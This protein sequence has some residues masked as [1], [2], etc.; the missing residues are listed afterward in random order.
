MRRLLHFHCGL[1]CEGKPAIEYAISC[2]RRPE[3][4]WAVKA[5][6][7]AGRSVQQIAEEMATLPGNIECFEQ[8]YFDA[9]PYLEPR[10]WLK[11][12][13]CGEGGH[14]WLEVALKRGWPG[15]EEVV[16]RR[17]PHGPRNLSPAVSIAVGRVQDYFFGQE[18]SNIAPSEKDL[19]LLGRMLRTHDKLPFLQ[20]S[21]PEKEPL[22]ESAA[23]NSFKKLPFASREK[24]CYF[25][26]QETE[27]PAWKAALKADQADSA[28][29]A[30]GQETAAPTE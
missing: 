9:R 12:I 5:M 1:A 29:S 6:V 17:L 11:N 13:C 30:T 27:G 3:S 20:D 21:L 2:L 14:R 16:L 19:E 22:P 26:R 18:A 10:F 25:L 28:T 15:V 23:F 8:L 4:A 7:V 24:V